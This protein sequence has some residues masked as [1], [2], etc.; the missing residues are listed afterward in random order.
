MSPPWCIKRRQCFRPAGRTQWSEFADRNGL[1]G[2]PLSS[3]SCIRSLKLRLLRSEHFADVVALGSKTHRQR[4]HVNRTWTT[5]SKR[6]SEKWPIKTSSTLEE[7]LSRARE[8][9][10][11]S[12]RWHSLAKNKS[13][14]RRPPMVHGAPWSHFEH[15][16]FFICV[17]SPLVSCICRSCKIPERCSSST[18]YTG[19]I[20]G[21]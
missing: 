2:T 5:T 4:D 19:S 20:H 1:V 14:G 3:S 18:W 16:F 17:A 10:M 11:V 7:P 13:H 15:I 21:I 8:K 9:L 6:E 12:L